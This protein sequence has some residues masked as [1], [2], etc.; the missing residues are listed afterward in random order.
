MRHSRYFTGETRVTTFTYQGISIDILI[1][2]QGLFGARWQEEWYTSKHLDG[3]KQT[4]RDK[5]RAHAVIEIPATRIDDDWHEDQEPTVEDVVI[6]GLDNRKG[7]IFYDADDPDKHPSPYYRH[8]DTFYHRLT[9]DE[10]VHFLE[11]IRQRNLLTKEIDEFKE[12]RKID[13]EAEV[14]KAV[15]AAHARAETV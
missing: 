6:T 2:P 7:L 9:H 8:S 1:D 10:R 4:L 14:G 3:L 15:K 12:S 13:G 11:L 5:I